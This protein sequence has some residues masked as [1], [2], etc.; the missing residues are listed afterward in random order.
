MIGKAR[1]LKRL[2]PDQ[3]WTKVLQGVQLPRRALPR[4]GFEHLLTKSHT[5]LGTAYRALTKLTRR[6]WGPKSSSAADRLPFPSGNGRLTPGIR[7]SD[8]SAQVLDQNNSPRSTGHRSHV[9]RITPEPAAGT[10][11]SAV[12]PLSSYLCV[13]TSTTPVPRV[14]SVGSSFGS[15]RG[16]SPQSCRNTTG[17]TSAREDASPKMR[18]LEGNVW[19]SSGVAAAALGAGGRNKNVV[20]LAGIEPTTLGFG[21]RYSIH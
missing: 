20:R 11:P 7:W 13:P 19:L 14:A 15:R 18:Y 3:V 16:C 2:F 9:L 21:G 4:C 6:C 1:Q 12:Q 5:S 8:T 17:A 10:L